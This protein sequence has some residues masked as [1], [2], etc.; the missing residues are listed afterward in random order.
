MTTTATSCTVK[1]VL[2]DAFTK[3]T[4]QVID[5]VATQN[6]KVCKSIVSFKPEQELTSLHEQSLHSDDR[7]SVFVVHTQMVQ[8]SNYFLTQDGCLDCLI[9]NVHCMFSKPIREN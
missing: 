1:V 6:L 3:L 5:A 7:S 8:L 2:V 4:L 9:A